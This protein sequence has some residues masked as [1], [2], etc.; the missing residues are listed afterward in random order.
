M[1]KIVKFL[2]SVGLLK[3]KEEERIMLVGNDAAGTVLRL[4][5]NEIL[6]TRV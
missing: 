6:L 5:T 2:G 1:A 4:R 3:L